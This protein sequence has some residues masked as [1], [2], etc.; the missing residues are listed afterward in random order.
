[1][2]GSDMNDDIEKNS[3]HNGSLYNFKRSHKNQHASP[4]SPLSPG[5]AS[6]G[7]IDLAILNVVDNSIEQLYQNICDMESSDES[8]STHSVTSYGNE[9]RIDSEL[10]HLVG[11]DNVVDTEEDIKEV[12][13]EEQHDKTP[14]SVKKKKKP[15][16]ANKGRK[17]EWKDNDVEIISEKPP[18]GKRNASRRSIS[19][20]SGEDKFFKNHNGTG[21]GDVEKGIDNPDLGPYL[22]KKARDINTL[23]DNPKRAFEFAL[24][25]KKSFESCASSDKRPSLDYVSCL[26]MLASMHCAAG[27]HKEAIPLL[28]QSIEIPNIELGQS[29]A[30]AKFVGCMQLGDVY[31]MMGQIEE[32]INLYKVGL[33]IQRTVLGVKDPR[34][35]ETCRYV[36]EAYLQILEFDEA[37]KLC[38]L[39]LDIHKENGCPPSIKEAADRRLMGLICDS[40]G[41]YEAA[42]EHYVLASMAMHCNGQESD[43][44]AVDCNIGDAYLALARYDDAIFTYKKALNAFASSKGKSHPTV[45][46]VFV[47]LGELYCKIGKFSESVSYCERALEI[48]SKP[49]PK[50]TDVEDIANGLTDLSAIY[51]SMNELDMSIK[52][53]KKALELHSDEASQK[54]KIAGIEAQMGV[55]N[56]MLGNYSDSYNFLKSSVLKFEDSGEKK[57][58]LYAITLNQLGLTCVQLSLISEAAE[59]FDKAMSI[60]EQEYGLFHP[61]TLGVYSNLAGT[62]D[63]LGRCDDA[64][65]LLEFVVVM[66]EEKLGTADPIVDEEKRRLAELLKEAGKAR[67]RYSRSLETLLDKDMQSGVIGTKKQLSGM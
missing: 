42:L 65:E 34:F 54:S 14:Q 30:L 63:A 21:R 20:S 37:G 8:Q 56:Y 67:R 36:A 22:L 45:A 38:K 62:Y 12:V 5:S 19:G 51:E 18:S 48:Y 35:G 49:P 17:V 47:R 64:I 40:K 61:D 10:R 52:L 24:R 59:L 13:V 31:A 44:A 7:S 4:I 11:A 23:G 58:S 46:S 29:Y 3:S 27:K 50:G 16:K 2:P 26:Q 25:A 39:A 60:L 41:D 1:M 32:A 33:E 9:S 66:R 28:E 53:L 15:K 57:S 43:V 6:I 55:L